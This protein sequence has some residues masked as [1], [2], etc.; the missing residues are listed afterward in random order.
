M[1]IIVFLGQAIGR[2]PD[3]LNSAGTAALLILNFRPIEILDTGFQ[4]SF[5]TVFSIGLLYRDIK[6]KLG[7]LPDRL[8]SLFAVT[9]SAQLGVLPLIAYHFNSL[10]LISFLTNPLLIPV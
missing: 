5:I 1:A 8:A 6:D 4:L 7:F 2:K 10:S 9:I 3:M